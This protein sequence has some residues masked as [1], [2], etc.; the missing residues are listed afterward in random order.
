MS[1]IIRTVFID[2]NTAD[3][4]DRGSQGSW[5]HPPKYTWP[6]ESR[7]R[8][9]AVRQHYSGG[10]RCV[11]DHGWLAPGLCVQD[12]AFMVD[13]CRAQPRR[14][15][16]RTCDRVCAYIARRKDQSRDVIEV[17]I[18]QCWPGRCIDGP[19]GECTGLPKGPY[20]RG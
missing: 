20:I 18:G 8:R 19:P 12:T 17:R 4:R 3:E 10:A 7:L 9:A 6:H 5:R 15:N 16:H 13:L 1:W 14:C 11:V 2:R